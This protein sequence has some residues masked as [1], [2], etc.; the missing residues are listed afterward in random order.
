LGFMRDAQLDATLRP[1]AFSLFDSTPPSKLIIPLEGWN[2]LLSTP[3]HLPHLTVQS[4]THF[5]SL[6]ES[7]QHDFLKLE[8]L[9]AE[10]N[11]T[12]IVVVQRNLLLGSTGVAQD[13]VIFHPE[14]DTSIQSAVPLQ[15]I[16][17]FPE[18]VPSLVSVL[19]ILRFTSSVCG[20]KYSVRANCYWFALIGFEALRGFR[21][22]P[23]LLQYTNFYD[24]AWK[25]LRFVLVPFIQGDVSSDVANVFVMF[26]DDVLKRHG[27]S[28]L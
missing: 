22:N 3:P 26:Y 12:N 6:L 17:W 13:E 14:G 21:T 9:N 25:E 10:T 20:C 18:E 8:V 4:V 7:Y 15:K 11:H 16:T 5:K 27:I 28:T 19:S 23:R 24:A 1:A 2:R